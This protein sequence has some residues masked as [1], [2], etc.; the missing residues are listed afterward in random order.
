MQNFRRVLITG[1]AGFAGSYLA[2]QLVGAGCE[3]FGTRIR[4][5]ATTNLSAVMQQLKV[6]VLDLRSERACAR[7]VGEIRPEAIFHL[8]AFS[9]VG[10]SFGDPELVMQVNFGGTLHLLDA[11]R[12]DQKAANALRVFLT[13]GSSDMYGRVKPAH[14]PLAEDQPLNPVSPY[15]ISKA[16][17]DFL[18]ATYHRAYGLPIIRVRAFNHTGPRQRAGFVVPDFAGRIARLEKRP[19]RRILQTGDLTARRDFTDVRDVARAYRLIARKGKPGEVY[20]VGSGKAV[21][22]QWV[23]KT[24]VGL[25]RRPISVVSDGGRTRPVDVSILRADI[26]RLTRLGWQPAITLKKTLL[27]ALEYYRSHI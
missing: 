20:H 7:L 23:V 26:T 17:A 4:G 12:H 27:D 2:E 14:L 15:A 8:A 9:D 18:A 24:L 10:A 3:V 25:A 22:I 1:A 21:S 13:V 19:G 6:R 11:L 16:A 5:E